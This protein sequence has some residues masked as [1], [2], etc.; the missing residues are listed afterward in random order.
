MQ[1]TFQSFAYFSSYFQLK[2]FVWKRDYTTSLKLQTPQNSP[3]S[4]GESLTKLCKVKEHLQ[5]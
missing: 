1:D 3:S 5:P 4:F 2:S